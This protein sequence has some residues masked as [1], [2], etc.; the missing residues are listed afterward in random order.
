MGIRTWYKYPLT[1]QQGRG[2]GGFVLTEFFVHPSNYVRST[3]KTIRS[4]VLVMLSGEHEKPRNDKED[5]PQFANV[6]SNYSVVVK[7]KP[8]SEKDK[9]KSWEHCS[10]QLF[11]R[12]RFFIHNLLS[13]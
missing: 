8:Y 7:E 9:E 13:E 12:R 10:P 11:F 4:L 2:D 3:L 5:W 6:K 1:S